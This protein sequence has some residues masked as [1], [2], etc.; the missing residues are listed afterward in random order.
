MKPT[1][2]MAEEARR[3]L[4]WRAEYNR[5]GTAIGVARARDISNRANLSP[6][7]IRRMVS[8]FARHEV[9][10]EAEGFRQG[11][12][13]YPSAGRIAWALWGGDAGK[14]WANQKNKQLNAENFM[15]T[16]ENKAAKVKL[17]DHVDKFS[18]DKLIDDIA[19]VY[20]MKAVE[21][22]YAF[23]EIIACADNAVDTLDVEIH[24][25]GGSVFEGYRIFNE[26]KKLRERGVYVTA[27]I[28]TLAASMGSVIA[29]AAD[30]VEIASNGKIMIHEASGGAQ[31]DSETLLRYAELLENISDEIAGVYAEKTGKDKDDIRVLMKKETWMTAKQA[32]EMGFADEIFDTKTNAMSILD[33][34]RPDAALTE[35]VQG[36]EASLESAQTE[37][38][39]MTAAL[40]ERTADLENALT[41]LSGIKAQIDTITAERDTLTASLTEA[42]SKVTELEANLVEA[43]TSAEA[44]AA[45]IVA[46]AGITPVDVSADEQAATDHISVMATLSPEEKTKYYN[47]HAKEIKS[48]LIK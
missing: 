16:I 47:Q 36:L 26:M 19:K 44:R 38:S 4:D 13:G 8:Y 24:S 40:T 30:K 1:A 11:E 48:Q 10:K 43:N 9:D 6:D 34:F 46:Q 31:G 28:N 21:N 3:G 29:M 25:G 14:S 20:G 39:D 42:Q 5:G 37:I 27:R 22:H 7:T 35:K 23:G 41:E 33:K 45:E 32:I 18:V 17:N 2:E 15:I 12:T